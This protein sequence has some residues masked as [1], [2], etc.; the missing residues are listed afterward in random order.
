M[1]E[2][3]KI[4]VI[5]GVYNP[6]REMLMRAVR[7]IIAQ[8]M[9]EWEMILY[10][11]GSSIECREIIRTAA[12]LDKRIY[13]V[14]NEKNRGLAYALNKCI[15]RAQGEYV[16]RMDDADQSLPERFEMKSA[17]LETKPG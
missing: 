9:K 1:S 7:S 17:F 14:R 6:D 2:S 15:R 16:A 10:D 12:A 11:D 13:Y 8:T 3:V 4:S 5:T